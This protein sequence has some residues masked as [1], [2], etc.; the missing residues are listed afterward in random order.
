MS[1]QKRP[2]IVIDRTKWRRGGNGPG[3]SYVE[4]YGS[5][6]LIN[7]KDNM[8]CLGQIARQCGFTE[9]DI[10][11]A[12]MPHDIYPFSLN[13]LKDGPYSVFLKYREDPDVATSTLGNLCQEVN[14][15]DYYSAAE[16]EARLTELLSPHFDISFVG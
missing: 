9:M 14:D 6:M 10:T 15:A 1:D 13:R 11:G 4:K 5:S 16:R 3:G 7:N 12:D 8:C 2:K